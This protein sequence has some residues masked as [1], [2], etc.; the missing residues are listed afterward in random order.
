[1]ATI[2]LAFSL[3]SIV[4]LCTLILKDG[5]SCF[6]KS[7]SWRGLALAVALVNSLLLVL[8]TELLGAFG[9]LQFGWVLALWALLAAAQI[10]F[11]R[12]IIT[13]LRTARE[14]SAPLTAIEIALI[15]DR[16]S[17]V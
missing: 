3:L 8:V 11:W 14:P 2:S 16:K 7:P 1:M 5:V 13:A 12:R 6:E 4:A 17:V 10:P 9:R 15:V